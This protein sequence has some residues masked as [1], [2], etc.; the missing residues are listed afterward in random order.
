MIVIKLQKKKIE[1]NI[2]NKKITDYKKKQF[3]RFDKKCN[4]NRY[5]DY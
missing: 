4:S 1:K 2:L 3:E 5:C